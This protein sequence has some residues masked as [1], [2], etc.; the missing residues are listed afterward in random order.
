MSSPKNELVIL[1]AEDD[2]DDYVLIQDV[3]QEANIQHPLQ[4]VKNGEELMKY[5]LKTAPSSLPLLILLDLNMPK[6]NGKEALK[7]IKSHEKL[8]KIPVIVLTTSQ[9]EEDVL[10][11]YQLGCNSFIRK[12]TSFE[13]FV[14]VIKNFKQYWLE[15]VV[16]PSSL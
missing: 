6:K 5:L 10:L 9:A 8:K 16:L 4:R 1:L 13:Q 15:S 14:E 11:S 2:D 3:F 7:E 12:P